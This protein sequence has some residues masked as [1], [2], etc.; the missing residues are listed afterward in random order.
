[1]LQ[2]KKAKVKISRLQK[3]IFKELK[4]LRRQPKTLEND[5]KILEKKNIL[6]AAV[7]LD[8][9]GSFVEFQSFSGKFQNGST[10]VA[11]YFRY[12]YM[13][14]WEALGLFTF[15]TDTE[16][17]NMFGVSDLTYLDAQQCGFRYTDWISNDAAES[18]V[19][20]NDTTF[21]GS[22]ISNLETSLGISGA[23]GYF[24][25][26]DSG[27]YDLFQSPS[28]IL[29]GQKI[30]ITDDSDVTRIVDTVSFDSSTSV[31]KESKALQWT[32]LVLVLF[33]TIIVLFNIRFP[34]RT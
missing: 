2:M 11:V 17:E 28:E 25:A 18:S 7:T 19:F 10:A 29:N 12:D 8:D 23:K 1:M 13:V 22:Q 21:S 20:F 16:A 3:N 14:D 24:D 26:Y 9:D 34:I 33:L 32:I 6:K 5:A 31:V 30:I 4:V 15:M 27:S